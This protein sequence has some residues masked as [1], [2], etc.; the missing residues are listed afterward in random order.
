MKEKDPNI[1]MRIHQNGFCGR[2]GSSVQ[3]HKSQ[4]PRRSLR[5]RAVKYSTNASAM[6]TST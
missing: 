2:A 6:Q 1:Q 3:L 5:E 4:K